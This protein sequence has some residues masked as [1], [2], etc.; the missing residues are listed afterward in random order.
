MTYRNVVAAVVRA[1]AAETITTA[2]GWGVEP[3]VQ[4]S[5]LCSVLSGKEAD[6]I[7]DCMIFSRLHK[8]LAPEHWRVLVAKYSTHAGRKHEAI[9]KLAQLCRSPAP[10]RFRHCAVVT[11]AM[12]RLRGAAGKRSTSVLPAAWYEMDNWCEE[13]HPI[14]TQERWRRDIR[15]VLEQ[16]VDEALLAA[17]SVLDAE[18]LIAPE[19]A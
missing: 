7:T 12:P 16:A 1:L 6:F 2:G 19:A 9:T 5:D 11:W 18:G 8:N 10:Q 13:P 15:K 14:K 17:Q 4:V 3:K